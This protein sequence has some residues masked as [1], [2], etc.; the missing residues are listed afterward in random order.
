MHYVTCIMVLAA[1]KLALVN[2]L[3]EQ[4]KEMSCR[5]LNAKSKLTQV[6]HDSVAALLQGMAPIL[7]G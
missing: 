5:I 7:G 6:E 2:G 4:K 3:L 1:G